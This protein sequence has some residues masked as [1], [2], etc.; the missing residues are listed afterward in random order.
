[1]SG[2]S[3]KNL[4][5]VIIPVYNQEHWVIRALNSIPKR[6]DIEIIV[7]DD[8]S[9]DNTWN[10]LLE[11]RCKNIEDRNII[12]LY[13]EENKGVGYTVNRGYDTASGEYI[14]LLG[15]DDY[16]TNSFEESLEELD[17]TDLIY[18]NLVDNTGKIWK[19]TP[20]TKDI[21]VGSVKFM[22]REFIG[23]TRCPEIR[24]VEDYYFYQE[25]MKKK[26]TEKFTNKVIKHYNYPR[27]GSLSY[28]HKRGEI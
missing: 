27:K 26:P 10:N 7:I 23:D 5:T 3:R 20:K 9:N 22:R 16:F 11:Y 4:V 13:N 2:N 6:D 25:L 21:L 28:M 15:S 19:V 14:V 24:A 18:F 8:G 17:G 1:M 12:L